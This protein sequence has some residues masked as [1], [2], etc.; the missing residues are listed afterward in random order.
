MGSGLG[1]LYNN[2]IGKYQVRYCIFFGS[3]GYFLFIAV[4]ILFMSL[5]FSLT[6]YITMFLIAGLAGLI[7]S[8]FYNS[9]YNYVNVLG[10]LDVQHLPREK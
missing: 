2:Y 7:A 1:S 8:V 10:Q 9:T 6:I 4:G 3:F 5:G